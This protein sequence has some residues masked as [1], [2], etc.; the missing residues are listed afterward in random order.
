MARKRRGQ[1]IDGWIVLDKPAG[2]SSTAAVARVRRLLDAAKAGH[3]GT[4]DPLATGILPIALG[5][6]TKTV[7]YVMDGMKT[8]RFTLRF[9][10]A[11]ATDD[12]EGEVIGVSPVR[13]TDDE[14]RAALPRFRGHIQQVP[15]AFS[16]VKVEG[17]RAYDLA[18]AGEPAELAAREAFIERFELIG[19]PSPEDAL[20]EVRSGKG[21]YMRSLARDLAK[22]LGSLGHVVALRRLSV[23]P[24]GE[25]QAIS[26]DSLEAM[27]HIPAASR[28][29]LP[30]AT[31]L[32]DIPALAVNDSEASRLRCGQSVGPIRRQDL[33][34]IGQFGSG[35]IFCAKSGGQPVALVRLEAGD[36]RPVRVLNL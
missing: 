20:F 30:V 19:R 2:L 32:D 23:G 22:A 10:E 28:H 29:L 35:A 5:E 34:R 24:F 12:A 21:A 4:L 16:A 8:Y 15:P 36:L 25:A 6:A 26:L 31:A 7:P 1:R 14:I 13:P 27:G 17:R 11:R 3:G 9:G 18:R 33:E